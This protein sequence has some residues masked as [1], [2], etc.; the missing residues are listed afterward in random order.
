VNYVPVGAGAK[1]QVLTISFA[2]HDA[3]API[4]HVAIAGNR[5]ETGL[6]AL[7]GQLS[8]CVQGDPEIAGHP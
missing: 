6:L 5:I 4:L 7:P 8:G 3:A 1:R 2:P